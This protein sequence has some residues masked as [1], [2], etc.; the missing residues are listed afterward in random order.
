MGP[1]ELFESCRL[2][3]ADAFVAELAPRELSAACFKEKNL[4]ENVRRNYITK[5]RIG[6]AT[7]KHKNKEGNGVLENSSAKGLP[8]HP[9]GA[10]LPSAGSRMLVLSRGSFWM[11]LLGNGR[12]FRGLELALDGK[13]TKTQRPLKCFCSS[14]APLSKSEWGCGVLGESG[15]G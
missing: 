11:E 6:L 13:Q 5:E 12:W 2:P 9:H 10:A 4:K 14:N 1:P 3:T 7:V 8:Q 15:R